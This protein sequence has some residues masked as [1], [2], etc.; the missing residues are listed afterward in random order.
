MEGLIILV[1]I[2]LFFGAR[3]VPQLGK[4]L[5]SGIREFRKE[6]A[7]GATDDKGELERPDDGDGEEPPPTN[8]AATTRGRM[9]RAGE[10]GTSRVRQK[11]LGE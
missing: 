5:G 4:S 8:G 9:P 1:L 10:D 6:T 7:A 11:P 2:L 3:R